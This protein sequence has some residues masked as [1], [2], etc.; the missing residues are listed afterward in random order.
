MELR[1]DNTI[2]AKEVLKNTR[3]NIKILIH[4]DGCHILKNLSVREGIK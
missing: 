1:Q 2:S 3:N 4:E